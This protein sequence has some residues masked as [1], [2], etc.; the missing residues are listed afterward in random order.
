MIITRKVIWS[1]RNGNAVSYFHPRCCNMWNEN[2][3]FMTL[4]SI[5]GS[6]FYGALQQSISSD[7]GNSWSDPIP[8][9]GYEWRIVPPGISE[10]VCD[11]VPEY[12]APTKT[13]LA[14]GHNVYYKDGKL[15]DSLG[16]WKRNDGPQLG[17]FPI[18]GVY[19]S[20]GKWIVSRRKLEI[21]GFENCSIYS[22]GSSQRQF[23]GEDEVLIPLTFGVFEERARH[24][25]TVL[26]RYDGKSLQFLRRG[27]T[28]S[29]PVDRGLLEPSLIQYK[30]RFLMTIRA[31]DE[32][33]YY[34]ESKN[35]LSWSEIH[36]WCF[37]DGTLLE[38]SSTQQHF[39]ALND[40]LFLI[41]TRNNGN[42]AEAMRF[43][44]PLYIAEINAEMQLIR[45]AER[46][47]LP[48]LKEEKHAAGMGNFHPVKLDE[49]HALVTVGEERWFEHYRGDTLCAK[50]QIE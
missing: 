34:A 25:T 18:W 21:P 39:L 19:D 14:I 8:V 38:T 16:D 44:A 24:V 5:S 20:S 42:N 7:R 17:R 3:V 11:V 48:I 10:G 6:D 27:N 23:L 43:R 26:C 28:L 22:C 47:L 12:H 49:T 30:G 33:G 37:D 36:P 50:I 29:L 2:G 4:Q 46:E 31:E 15:F 32:R 1:N 45:K 13:I 40:R 41:Y 35:G 9:P